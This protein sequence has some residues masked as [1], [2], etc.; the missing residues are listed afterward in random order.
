MTPAKAA[1]GGGEKLMHGD[2]FDPPAAIH[3]GA[4]IDV[5]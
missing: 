1:G 5:P 3:A 4:L 2:T